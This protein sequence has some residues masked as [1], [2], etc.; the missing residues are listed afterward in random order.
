MKCC[1]HLNAAW[2]QVPSVIGQCD[3]WP[4]ISDPGAQ[5]TGTNQKEILIVY[6]NL[7][8]LWERLFSNV[9][10]TGYSPAPDARKGQTNKRKLRI[11]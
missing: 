6:Q 10:G 11:E 1:M 5:G 3:H 9:A 7:R 8:K 2:V 4:P